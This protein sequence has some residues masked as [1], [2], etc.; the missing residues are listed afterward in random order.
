MVDGGTVVGQ[1]QTR[2]VASDKKPPSPASAQS[3]AKRPQSFAA[4]VKPH[5]AGM[6][7][8]G[9]TLVTGV[10]GFIGFHIARYYLR[11]GCRVVGVDNPAYFASGSLHD[12]RLR[13]LRREGLIFCGGDLARQDFVADVAARHRPEWVFHLAAMASVRSSETRRFGN[14][15]IAGLVSVLAALRANSPAHFLFASSSS[16]YGERA[17]RPFAESYAVAAADNLYADSKF[18]GERI[19]RFWSGDFPMTA[20]RF[21]NVY[22]PWGRPNMAP[23]YFTDCL[24]RDIEVRLISPEVRRAWL[25]IDD[26]VRACVELAQAA[27]AAGGDPVRVVNIAGPELVRTADALEIIARQ[28]GRRP[29]VVSCPPAV[30]EVT[31]NP[32]DLTALKALLGWTPQT[33]FPAGVTKLIAWYQSEW[34]KH[35]S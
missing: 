9:T 22:G 4:A 27:Q 23:L 1:P 17:P 33:R 25:Y 34:Q 18:I 5:Y 20:V 29:R 30:A 26:A 14:D 12:F 15:N 19:L 24:A 32:A 3:G 2:A 35:N 16:V 7:A 31:S 11:A 28:M 13:T 6:V 8:D 10:A 21:F